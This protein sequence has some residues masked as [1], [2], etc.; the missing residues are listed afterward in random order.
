MNRKEWERKKTKEKL[1]EA[2]SIYGNEEEEKDIERLKVSGADCISAFIF[3]CGYK[4]YFVESMRMLGIW[5]LYINISAALTAKN[6]N[7]QCEF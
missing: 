4:K 1:F 7:I 2:L 3:D 6:L 5:N